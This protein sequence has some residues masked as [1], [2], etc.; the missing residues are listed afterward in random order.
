VWETVASNMVP[1]VC[2][3]RRARSKTGI[4]RCRRRGHKNL[5]REEGGQTDPRTRHRRRNALRRVAGLP[6]PRA[7]AASD[8]HCMGAGAVSVPANPAAGA[9]AARRQRGFGGAR[10]RRVPA[11]AS[12]E[13]QA[14]E[15]DL[16]PA[17]R[18]QL[19]AH[20]PRPLLRRRRRRR[21]R[22]SPPREALAPEQAQQPCRAR[23]KRRSARGCDHQCSSNPA[24]WPWR[25]RRRAERAGARRPRP[26]PAGSSRS[27]SSRPRRSGCD[28]HPCLR[29]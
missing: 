29:C 27:P 18:S 13:G 10:R 20:A 24:R 3:I 15:R 12:G 28:R 9:Q 16:P 1:R 4:P 22:R 14:R 25:R 5:R 21:I 2:Q 8:R 23:V 26:V 11:V 19:R 7:R 17:R 6:L